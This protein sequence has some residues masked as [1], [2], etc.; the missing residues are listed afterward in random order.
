M[1]IKKEGEVKQ[2]SSGTSAQHR[3]RVKRMVSANGEEFGRH[4]LGNEEEAKKQIKNGQDKT[5]AKIV[6]ECLCSCFWAAIHLG[7]SQ[8]PDLFHYHYKPVLVKPV[9][10][11]KG[12]AVHGC[13]SNHGKPAK[14]PWAVDGA[15]CV[16]KAEQGSCLGQQNIQGVLYLQACSW[17]R[18]HLPACLGQLGACSQ[19]SLCILTNFP[20]RHHLLFYWN[21]P[22]CICIFLIKTSVLRFS[23][24]FLFILHTET[25]LPDL[26]R[27]CLL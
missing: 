19:C 20:I 26:K 6:K 7:I 12:Y 8:V 2:E 16:V 4:M 11:G 22:R 17:G 10:A 15:V 18:T 9:F 24:H 27:P 14:L 13:H 1:K 21:I 23:L 5:K 25:H 3:E